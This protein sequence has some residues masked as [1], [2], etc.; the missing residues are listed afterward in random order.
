MIVTPLIQ[1]LLRPEA[2]PHEVGKLELIETHISWVL[3]TGPY[4]Y[5]IKKPIKLEFLDFRLLSSRKKFCDVELKLNR[6]WAPEIYLDVVTIRQSGQQTAV[7]ETGRVIE[8][9]VKMKQFPQSA[10]LDAQ[11]DAGA[12]DNQDMRSFAELLANQ[13]R[14]AR[15]CDLNETHGTLSYIRQPMLENF[16]H[17]T[18]DFKSKSVERLRDWTS[19]KL[20]RLHSVLLAR[21]REGFIRVCH[22][23][24][25]LAN[26]VRLDSGIRAF[27]CIEF[28]EKLR[29]IDVISDVAFLAMDLVARQRTDLA[30]QF[31]NRYLEISGD[32]MGMQLFDLYF[33]YHCL[34]R[35]KVAMIRSSE[36]A[37]VADAERDMVDVMH[38]I[39]V[40]EDCIARPF[41]MLIAMHGLSGSG[42]TWVSEQVMRMMPAIR[43]RSDIERK[44]LNALGETGHSH[45]SVGHGLYREKITVEVY[46]RLRYLATVLLTAGHTV[47]IDAAFLAIEERR[48]LEFSAERLGVTLIFLDTRATEGELQARLIRR[49]RIGKDASEASLDVLRY[50][51]QTADE[52]VDSEST[53]VLP[54]NTDD[55]ILLPKLIEQIRQC[56]ELPSNSEQSAA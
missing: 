17:L 9:A 15:V 25:H 6:Q 13:H 10:R 33:V 3:L 42:K 47:I 51:Q 29:D 21:Q 7:G 49:A 43:V 20:C 40:A 41:P 30:Y 53:H 27:D 52:L 16:E 19:N 23:D 56:G 22:G 11:L 4:A 12:L 28:S 55:E 54:V 32:Y 39:A 8:Y 46:D 50:Q 18:K 45:S 26:M 38:Y 14:Q 48:K 5:K 24:L 37:V 35:A 31:L 44:R 34:I 2:Y 1:S 36:R